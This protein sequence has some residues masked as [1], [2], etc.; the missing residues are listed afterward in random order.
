MAQSRGHGEDDDG[1]P[2]PVKIH[3]ARPRRVGSPPACAGGERSGRGGRRAGRRPG[4]SAPDWRGHPGSAR[5]R[6]SRGRRRGAQRLLDGLHQPVGPERLVQDR[7][8]ALLPRLD[9]RV[10]R[11]PAEPRH[12]D[13]RHV[14]LD[15]AEAL[16][17]LVAVQ[18]GQADVDERRRVRGLP[19][20]RDGLVGV[21]GGLDAGPL[22]AEQVVGRPADRLVGVDHED[23]RPGQPGGGRR[24]GLLGRRR[25][26]RAGLVDQA[27]D[28]AAPG[29]AD[30]G[31]GR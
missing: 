8:Q 6:R 12:Q 9:D 10:R 31:A 3:D 14:G 13:D 1:Q 30:A 22:A 29:R 17:G 4:R 16:V 5:R 26:R 11:V 15:L 25:D 28:L 18:V 19:H 27:A 2:W 20:Q 7:L 23:P 21:A 24:R